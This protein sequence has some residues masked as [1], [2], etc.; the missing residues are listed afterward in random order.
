MD[1]SLQYAH[2]CKALKNQLKIKI[3]AVAYVPKQMVTFEHKMK[4]R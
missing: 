3:L 2:H 1:Q 4:G